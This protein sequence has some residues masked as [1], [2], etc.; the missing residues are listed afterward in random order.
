MSGGVTIIITIYNRELFIQEAINSVINQTY[1]N[2]NLLIWDDGSTD[3]SINI[4]NSF[5]ELDK[6]IKL[7]C[8][9]HQGQT[10]SLLNAMSYAQKIFNNKYFGWLDSD[11]ILDQ[12]ALSLTTKVLDNNLKVGF[13]Y[14]DY[15]E[16][17]TAGNTLR[18]G[19]R[20]KIAYCKNNLLLNFMTF[21]FRLVR[22][23]LYNLIGGLDSN[24]LYVQD[25]DL[26]LKLSEVSSVYH[27]PLPLYFYRIHSNNISNLKSIDIL[28]YS[29]KA[30][31]N[32]LVR[33]NLHHSIKLNITPDRKFKLTR[34]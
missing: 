8:C 30:V 10:L 14:T 27:I 9:K 26:C 3:N 1:D 17:D 15:M 24:I 29:F 32:A 34:I 19:S 21:H 4:C 33:R 25:Y 6:R 16:I 7:V 13:V 31:N 18:L 28:N 22:F 20:C 12:N 11:D 2:W 23:D 5:C